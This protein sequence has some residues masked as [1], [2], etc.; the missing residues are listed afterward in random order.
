[1][2]RMKK[3][4]SIAVAI[5]LVASVGQAVQLTPNLESKAAAS[6][7][8]CGSPSV[9]SLSCSGYGGTIHCT[10]VG[11]PG[12]DTGGTPCTNSSGQS[13]YCS[14]SFLFG[15]NVDCPAFPV[16]YVAPKPTPT[17]YSFSFPTPTPTP[18]RYTTPTTSSYTPIPTYSSGTS[19]Q[20]CVSAPLPPIVT[21]T[22]DSAG[23]TFAVSPVSIPGQETIAYI[24][25]FVFGAAGTATWG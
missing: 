4:F 14:F 25:R 12:I 17:P 20:G 8:S 2:C 9:G 10:N 13:V 3:L 11:T 18:F 1:M 24:T 6:S 19:V 16:P 15:F 7:Y 5:F 22:Q 21:A 23:V